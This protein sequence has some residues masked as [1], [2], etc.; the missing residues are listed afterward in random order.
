MVE[1]YEGI[2]VMRTC[3]AKKGLIEFWIC[4]DFVEQFKCLIEGLR[5]EF[6]VELTDSH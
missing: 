4:P 3:D 5:D 1:A 2:G 6:P